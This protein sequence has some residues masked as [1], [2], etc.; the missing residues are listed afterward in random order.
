MT[1]RQKSAITLLTAG[2]PRT[3]A[4]SYVRHA[5]AAQIGELVATGSPMACH[6]ASVNA[7]TPGEALE[8]AAQLTAAYIATGN[9]PWGTSQVLFRA[10]MHPHAT[11]RTLALARAH[12]SPGAAITNPGLADTLEA[13]SQPDPAAALGRLPF[14]QITQGA[15]ATGAGEHLTRRARAT[16]AQHMPQ[17]VT[18]PVAQALLALRE[19]FTG[20][21]AQLLTTATT[22]AR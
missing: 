22:V 13:V 19:S 6:A 4:G 11:E 12:V 20:T 3:E 21:F 7:N 2:A 18:P 16:F 1:V 10:A 9:A 14:T 5:P 17:P 8:R 15:H